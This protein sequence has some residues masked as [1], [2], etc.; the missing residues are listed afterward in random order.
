MLPSAP[1]IAI[2]RSGTES[3]NDSIF[4]LENMPETREQYR[5]RKLKWS[6]DN[7]EY[8]RQYRQDHREEYRAQAKVYAERRFFKRREWML[9]HNHPSEVVATAKQL[10]S[11]WKQQRGR[12]PFTN[13]KLTA[14]NAH[15]DH[16]NPKIKGGSGS[17]ENLRWVHKDVNYAKRDL[18]D[19][20]FMAL[21]CQIARKE[22]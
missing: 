9:R 20:Q 3:K 7:V 16:I 8:Y 18:T 14:A 13:W 2:L 11:L 21:C 10:A 22:G 5:A 15:L 1:Q 12:C 6:R 19:I 17:I 4:R